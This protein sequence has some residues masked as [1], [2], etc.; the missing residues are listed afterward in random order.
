MKRSI[1]FGVAFLCTAISHSQSVFFKSSQ[2]IEQRHL[3]PFYSSVTLHDS[4]VLFNAVDYQLY[5]FDGNSGA[6]K[7]SYNLGR[8]SDAGP[9]ICGNLVF[10]TNGSSEVVLLDP[11]TGTLLKTLP[12]SSVETQPYEKNGIVYFTGLFDGGSLIAYDPQADSVLWKRFLAHG[13]SVRPYYLADRIVANAEGDNW[14]EV[15]YDGILTDPDCDEGAAPGDFPSQL[16]CARQFIARTHDGKE[17]QGKLANRLGIDADNLPVMA[18]ASKHSFIIQEGTLTILGNNL[19]IKASL[20]LATLAG[21]LAEDT[22]ARSTI[23][24]AG[25]ETITLLFSNHLLTYDHHTKKLLKSVDL[26]HWAPHDAVMAGNKLWLIS[27]KD[28]GLYGIEID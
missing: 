18:Y 19:K 28:G 25:N 16:P 13:V 7:W 15:R 21:D 24:A 12:V 9:F 6:E 26:T 1:F 20:S 14:I 17:I 4:L 22:D 2:T 5:A 10:A 27:G 3:A 8:K 23:L 11:A